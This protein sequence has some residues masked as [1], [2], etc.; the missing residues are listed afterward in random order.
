MEKSQPTIIIS[1]FQHTV[2]TVFEKSNDATNFLN[3]DFIQNVK[4]INDLQIAS[5]DGNR[6]TGNS[7]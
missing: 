2:T 7:L 4:T 3:V 1:L 6:R 5:T